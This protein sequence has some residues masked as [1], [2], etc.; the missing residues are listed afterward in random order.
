MKYRPSL[1]LTRLAG[2]WM[3][4]S[5]PSIFP[6]QDWDIIAPIPSSPVAYRKRLFHPCAEFA[7]IL[8]KQKR[9]S[10]YQEVLRHSSIRL[11]QALRTHSER[12]KGLKTLFKCIAG[13]DLVGCNIL[14]V[15][16]VITTGA[17][18]AAAAYTL[19]RAGAARIEVYALAQTSVWKR[20][21]SRV[22]TIFTE[23]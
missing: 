8:S 4:D 15:E 16:D 12:L 3:A 17:T 1:S 11:P 7:R 5:I 6:G 23:E 22:H 9:N 19:R 10:R 13:R 20:F 21:R 2:G 18:I 14:L